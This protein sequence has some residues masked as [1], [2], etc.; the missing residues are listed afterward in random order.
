MFTKEGCG[1]EV[2]QVGKR[3]IME[4]LGAYADIDEAVDFWV[5]RGF[6]RPVG[7]SGHG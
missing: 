2:Y 1:V 3:Q 4:L 7:G 5:S 6:E